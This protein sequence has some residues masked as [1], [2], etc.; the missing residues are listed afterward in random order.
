MDGLLT[1]RLNFGTNFFLVALLLWSFGAV[2]DLILESELTKKH[3][4]G[5]I[6][7]FND[8]VSLLCENCTDEAKLPRAIGGIKNFP[9]FAV[10]KIKKAFRF[11]QSVPQEIQAIVNDMTDFVRILNLAL[12]HD[13]GVNESVFLNSVLK[14]Q[15]LFDENNIAEVTRLSE[16]SIR[17]QLKT[18]LRLLETLDTTPSPE[19]VTKSLCEEEKKNG[20]ESCQQKH[21]GL[22]LLNRYFTEIGEQLGQGMRYCAHQTICSWIKSPSLFKAM[23]SRRNMLNLDA[24]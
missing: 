14:N 15:A 10:A 2:S 11:V 22:L 6:V 9:L 17:R 20:K 5:S 19:Q 13:E 3:S 24:R 23:V 7:S 18:K 21:E 1:C 8:Y 16:E 12:S 4:A